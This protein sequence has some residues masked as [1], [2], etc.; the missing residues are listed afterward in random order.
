MRSFMPIRAASA[1][2]HVTCHPRSPLRV[3]AGCHPKT[4]TKP[5]SQRRD[6]RDHRERTDRDVLVGRFRSRPV[7]RLVAGDDGP[8]LRAVHAAP[9]SRRAAGASAFP[10]RRHRGRSARRLDRWRIGWISRS[11]N[12]RLAVEIRSVWPGSRTYATD[13]LGEV[14]YRQAAR[15]APWGSGKS[16]IWGTRSRARRDSNPIPTD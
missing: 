7:R 15:S 8:G 13:W 10:S 1:E 3:T 6:H 4:C 16:P 2:Q 11:L 5:F 9:T 12:P 14:S